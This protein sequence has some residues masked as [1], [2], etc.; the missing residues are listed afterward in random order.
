MCDL[1]LPPPPGGSIFL[2]LFLALMLWFD[3]EL[4]VRHTAHSTASRQSRAN[5][6]TGNKSP[7][8]ASG[9]SSTARPRAR[10]QRFSRRA[11]T[12]SLVPPPPPRFPPRCIADKRNRQ[13][14]VRLPV[15]N[16]GAQYR[17]GIRPERLPQ[18]RHGGGCQGAREGPWGEGGEDAVCGDGV[19]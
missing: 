7:A 5:T 14:N 13:S 18:E 9:S 15:A 16:T 11:L 12:T 19:L 2:L 10:A 1:E 8:A 4:T 17:D 3:M 6:T